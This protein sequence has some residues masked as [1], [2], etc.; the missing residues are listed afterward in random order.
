MSSDLWHV[1][2]F[3]RLHLGLS[4]AAHPGEITEWYLN[5]EEG[6]HRENTC[7]VAFT[8]AQLYT[9]LKVCVRCPSVQ[10]LMSHKMW[11]KSL[12]HDS[13]SLVGE[14]QA[15]IHA[16]NRLAHAYPQLLSQIDCEVHRREVELAQ[17]FVQHH[18]ELDLPDKLRA[19]L[20]E[21]ADPRGR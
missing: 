18:S 19:E 2:M 17:T 9:R 3:F 15:L 7:F 1:C 21:L 16:V 20:T 6:L 5:P 13:F 10:G 12:G 8:A 11:G 4:L 14:L